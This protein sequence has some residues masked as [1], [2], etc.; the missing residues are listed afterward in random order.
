[1]PRRFASDHGDENRR[2]SQLAVSFVVEYGKRD[3][4]KDQAGVGDVQDVP[5]QL[6]GDGKGAVAGRKAGIARIPVQNQWRQIGSS[7]VARNVDVLAVVAY[8]TIS[9]NPWCD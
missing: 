2:A 5:Q 1:M 6:A 8:S 7:R 4:P 9:R 3:D